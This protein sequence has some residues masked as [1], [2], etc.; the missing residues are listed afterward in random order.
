VRHA[1]GEALDALEPVLE[2]VRAIPGLVERTRGVFYR[3][4]GSAFLHFHED[5]AGPFAD[6]RLAAGWR[7]MRARTV[8]ERAAVVAAAR[9][10]AAALGR[11]AD[12]GLDGAPRRPR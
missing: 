8:R 6:L 5:P 10:A 11:D 2:R 9:R 7:R 4:G 3:R 1:R 12:P